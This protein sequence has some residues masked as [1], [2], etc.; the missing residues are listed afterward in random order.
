[1]LKKTK[2]LLFAMIPHLM[3]IEDGSIITDRYINH[4]VTLESV[5]NRLC[6]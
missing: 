2:T 3:I 6:N 5:V 1:M 4:E